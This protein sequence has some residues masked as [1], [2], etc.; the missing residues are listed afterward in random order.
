MRKLISKTIY[1]DNIINA[2]QV[3]RTD[4]QII[5]VERQINCQLK[6]TQPTVKIKKPQQIP[7]LEFI[8]NGH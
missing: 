8:K 1:K 3:K 4:R 6:E 2:K 7:L 5:F